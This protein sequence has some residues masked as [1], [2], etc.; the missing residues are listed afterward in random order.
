MEPLSSQEQ[1]N[2]ILIQASKRCPWPNMVSNN[3]ADGA[4]TMC[5]Q[6]HCERVGDWYETVRSRV[7]EGKSQPNETPV[8]G[9]HFSSGS[10]FLFVSNFTL[11]I[12]KG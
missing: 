5:K 7:K 3:S 6:C 8:G 1:I 2:S 9:A 4:S 12:A 11:I 10:V